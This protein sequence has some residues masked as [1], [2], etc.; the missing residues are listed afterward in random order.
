MSG[1][2]IGIMIELIVAG[3][4][5][6]T[7]GYCFILNKRLMRLKAD[8]QALRGTITELINATQIAERAIHGLKTTVRECDGTLGERL[9]TAERFL[10]ALDHEKRGAEDLLDR[11]SKIASAGRA[12]AV[13]ASAAPAPAKPSAAAAT[14][15]AA[16][17]FTSRSKLMGKNEAA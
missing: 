3:L 2:V 16:S 14:L 6:V 8:E 4:L 5:A 15:A 10:S 12:A 9:R 17:A 13:S 1:Q 11:I 7:I